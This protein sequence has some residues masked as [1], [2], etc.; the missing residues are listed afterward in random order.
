MPFAESLRFS[1]ESVPFIIEIDLARTRT[2]PAGPLRILVTAITPEGEAV[3]IGSRPVQAGE[4]LTWQG[5]LPAR[6]NL[7]VHVLDAD[8]TTTS[9]EIRRNAQPVRL[10]I[11][12]DE[13]GNFGVSDGRCPP[14]TSGICSGFELRSE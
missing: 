4:K 6:G 12:G 3:N 13:K 1:G 10:V 8:R 9:T 7:I 11:I 2:Q 14:R 5:R